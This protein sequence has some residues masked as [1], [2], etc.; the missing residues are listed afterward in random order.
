LGS[1]VQGSVSL[2]VSFLCTTFPRKELSQIFA[3]IPGGPHGTSCI[4]VC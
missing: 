1:T 2:L 3:L 4:A